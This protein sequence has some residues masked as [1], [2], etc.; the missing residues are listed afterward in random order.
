M[1][2][3][4]IRAAIDRK[5]DQLIADIREIVAI[6]SVGGPAEP[7]APFG[8]GPRA[9]LEKFVEMSRRLGFRAW[10]FADG[11][12][13]AELGD[14]SLP[15][16]VG[17]LAHLDVVPAGEGWSCDPWV[18]KV[19]D[20]F[21]YGR[22]VAD[23][24]GPAVSVLY[25]MMALRDEGVKLK[26][27]IRLIVG[28]NEESGSRAI[29][30]YVAA[31]Q[32]IPVAGFTPDADF[33]LINGEK[34]VITPTCRAPFAPDG[35]AVQ[36]VSLKAGV[37]SNAV[38]SSATA[39][40]RVAPE[41]VARL[42]RALEDFAA[43][44]DASLKCEESGEGLYTLTMTGLAFHGSRPQ[45]GS[46]AAAHLVS[47]LRLMGIGGEQGKFL[48]TIDCLVGHQTRGENLGVALYDDI[49]GFSSLC[50]GMIYTEGSEI[51]F[52]LNYRFPVTFKLEEV[53]EKF[54]S[55]LTSHG[56]T[57]EPTEGMAP[58]YV[59]ENS[60]LVKALMR[61]YQDETGDTTSRP[62][63]IGG[64]TYAKEMPN[65]VAFGNAMPGEATHI[66]ETDERWSVDH[67]I[68]HTKIMAAALGA[69]AG[70]ED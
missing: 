43:P 34:G 67:I 35:G 62:M 22:G 66:H 21:V 26:R 44:R 13:I 30:G 17:V 19:E 12:G 10:T 27:R 63:S 8:P 11:V 46:N 50:W 38:P 23:D 51:V 32:E 2:M 68:T 18:G 16:M 47:F 49:S 69:L 20:G 36:V 28:T 31:G 56:I 55:A 57:V 3:E 14:E 39:V 24:K 48:E 15:E 70:A 45:F 4:S 52:T 41:A 40:L 5:S 61:A 53:H 60:A 9:A 7:G 33:P 37:A 6:P 1:N 58:L 29:Q 42:N 65:I 64:G 59:P 54:L 25:A